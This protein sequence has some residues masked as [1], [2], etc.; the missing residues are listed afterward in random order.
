MNVDKY[1]DKLKSDLLNNSHWRNVS[2]TTDWANTFPDE[3]G[4]YALKE[5]NQIIYVGETGNIRGRMKDLLDSRHHTVRRT[6]GERYFSKIKGFRKATT[7]L[8]FPDKIEQM[9]N[10]YILKNIK[11]SHLE[12]PLG[13]KELEE[14]IEGEIHKDVRL[15]KRGKRKKN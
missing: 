1:L 2:L 15:N 13:R 6:I 10:D 8:R 11:V 7:K 14:L 9:V 12:V 3:A 5:D 4:V